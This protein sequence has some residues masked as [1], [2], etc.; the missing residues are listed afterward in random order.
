MAKKE[1][2]NWATA[3][4][5]P[6]GWTCATVN[7]SP[8]CA[9]TVVSPGAQCIGSDCFCGISNEVAK[10][11]APPE[12]KSPIPCPNGSWCYESFTCAF[13]V[14][15]TS[16]H[17]LDRVADEGGIACGVSDGSNKIRMWKCPKSAKCKL[18]PSNDPYCE[19]PEAP[20]TAKLGERCGNI[21]GG[22]QCKNPNGSNTLTCPAGTS[23]FIDK[24]MY[25]F[26][27]FRC[28]RNG[29]KYFRCPA[30]VSCFCNKKIYAAQLEDT[31]CVHGA[32]TPIQS[33]RPKSGEYPLTD[34]VGDLEQM[35]ERAAREALEELKKAMTGK[36]KK[37]TGSERRELIGFQ[38]RSFV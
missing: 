24:A 33:Q 34:T 17:N 26:T 14:H 35:E 36:G 9:Q 15:P 29:I 20:V 7:G 3:V 18:T 13:C 4:V 27:T 23:C 32:R 31:Y 10:I 12:H 16:A 38:T 28:K 8:T 11:I 19:G 2:L 30:G 21:K 37:G 5:C 1:T 6:K 25:L 22:C